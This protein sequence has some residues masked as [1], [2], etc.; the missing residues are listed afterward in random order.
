MLVITSIGGAG[1]E[2]VVSNLCRH[3]DANRFNVCVCH[4]KERGEKGDALY[5]QGYD[6]VGLPGIELRKPNYFAALKLRELVFKKRIDLLHS[7]NLEPL[8]ECGLC[9]II[10]P[11][12]KL[13]HTYHFGNYPH[14]PIHYLLMEAIHSRVA[15]KLV[16]VGYQQKQQIIETYKLKTNIIETVYN[17]IV[18]ANAVTHDKSITGERPA[19]SIIIGSICTFIRQKGLDYLLQIANEVKIRKRN[20]VFWVAGDG[21]LRSQLEKE[22][23]EMGLDETVKFLGWIPNAAHS[24]LPAMDIFL[25]TSR[26]EA[27][28]MVILEAMAAGKPIVATDVGENRRIVD[29]AGAGFIVRQGDV[30][31]TASHLERLATQPELRLKMGA[32]GK[33]AVREQYSVTTMARKYEALYTRVLGLHE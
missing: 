19:D 8:L 33:M 7:H 31:S 24:V 30:H 20:V 26:W 12:V 32:S 5:E 22:K 21:P 16:A 23:H 25:Q 6:I 11:K 13:I 29:A 1:A 28:S 27:M 14:L 10:T 9:K 2:L 17:G 18:P 15:D 4:L 3:L